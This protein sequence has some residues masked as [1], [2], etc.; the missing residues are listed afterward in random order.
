MGLYHRG[1]SGFLS[2]HS[3]LTALLEINDS[4]FVHID[5]GLLNGVIFID[6]KKAFDTIDQEINN[7]TLTKCGVDQDALKWFKSYLINRMQRC[8]VTIIYLGRAFYIVAYLKGQQS[9]L[10]FS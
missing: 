2:L 9:V 7:K 3:T 8:N 10:C 6:L 4:W 5:R 1:Q